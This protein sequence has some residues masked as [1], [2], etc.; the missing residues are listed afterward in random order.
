MG[1]EQPRRQALSH[2]VS[3]IDPATW[4]DL[5]FG[6]VERHAIFQ[7]IER[8][9]D[10]AWHNPHTVGFNTR[11]QKNPALMSK[12]RDAMQREASKPTLQNSA[13]ILNGWA[14]L[15]ALAA[16]CIRTFATIVFMAIPSS[17]LDAT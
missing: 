13:T 9:V 16:S 15:C 7:P 4:P 14:S 11:F 6:D 10:I 17:G 1:A 2:F 3:G 5:Q 12:P 8:P